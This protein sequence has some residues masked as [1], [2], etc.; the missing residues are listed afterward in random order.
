MAYEAAG[1]GAGSGDGAVKRV[2]ESRVLVEGGD[3]ADGDPR[4]RR[5]V[6][7]RAC[8]AGDVLLRERPL[9]SALGVGSRE[10]VCAARWRRAAGGERLLRCSRCGVLRYA[11]RD[12]QR[13]AWPTHRRECAALASIGDRERAVSTP[14]AMLLAMR[15]LWQRAASAEGAAAYDEHVVPL[16]THWSDLSDE[17]KVSFSAM[18]AATRSLMAGAEGLEG[19]ARHSDEDAQRLGLPPVR[20]VTQLLAALACNAHTV[21]DENLHP[22]GVALYGMAALANHSCAPAAVQGFEGDTIVL[23]ALRSI[24]EGEEVTISYVDVL[25]PWEQRRATLLAEY[26]FDA[27]PEMPPMPAPQRTESC[28]ALVLDLGD[29]PGVSEHAESGREV[30]RGANVCAWMSSALDRAVDGFAGLD[31]ATARGGGSAGSGSS[32]TQSEEVTVLIYGVPASARDTMVASAARLVRLQASTERALDA[33]D[34]VAAEAAIVGAMDVNDDELGGPCPSLRLRTMLLKL[35]LHIAKQAWDTALEIAEE[36]SDLFRVVGAHNNPTPEASMHFATHAKLLAYANEV[37][38]TDLSCVCVRFCVCVCGDGGS[39]GARS[40]AVSRDIC[41]ERALRMSPC[42]LG[43][44]A[45]SLC[46]VRAR[47]SRR[48]GPPR[49]QDSLS[50]CCGSRTAT[51]RWPTR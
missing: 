11:G 29:G 37:R 8:A 49:W 5:L 10:G 48:R 16:R 24:S 51:A 18:G 41:C 44:A 14:A 33:H 35:R 12:A 23:R 26:H 22:L 20:E 4:G 21:C 42:V 38:A 2:I 1:G 39:V 34:L 3:D 19:A 46:P 15:L 28:G 13:A 9:A 31:F 40:C 25:L 47:G 6:A 32:A 50:A 17:R 43:P 36:V 45:D 7:A 30:A 27:R